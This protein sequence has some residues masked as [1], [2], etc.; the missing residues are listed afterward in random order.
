MKLK[1]KKMVIIAT[2]VA[3]ALGFVALIFLDN[4][5]PTNNAEDASLNLNQNKDIN[6]LIEKYFN[7]K[8]TVNIEAMSEL[9]SDANRI[10]KDRYTILAS[11]VE[12]YKD[13]DCY[14][15][16]N[17]ETDSYRVYV[18]YN[19]KLKNIESWVPCLTKYYVKVTSE[20]KYV[21]YFSA[22]DDAEVE[23]INAADKNDEI[24]KLKEDVNKSM[25]SI[26]EKDATFKQYYQKMQKEIKAA[27][28]E[29]ASG[30]PAS[31]AASASTSPTV[32]AAP[33]SASPATN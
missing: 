8:K 16:R 31:S 5:G 6:Q 3:M 1:Y 19:M 26:L 4:D 24:Q 25:T 12:N 15:I 17:E 28:N 2:V 27:S 14:Y 20:G 21:I 11:Y 29:A 9:V 33:A 32:S 18:K 30:A 7:A 23:F 22:L 10:P 13:F